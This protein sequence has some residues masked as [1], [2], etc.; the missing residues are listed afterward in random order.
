MPYLDAALAFALTMLVVATLVTQIVR[1]LKNTANVRRK[2]LED[3]LKEYFKSEFEPVVQRELNRL[4]TT[5]S[6]QVFTDLN[7]VLKKFDASLQIN[8]AVEEKLVDMS[9]DELTERL[10]RSDL[11]LKLLADLGDKAQAVFD[12]LGKR[13]EVVGKKFTESFRS[14]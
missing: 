14:K 6:A 12:E 2:G 5:V 9:T 13:Y 10:K 4:T 7:N 1:V 3:M 11:G 8:K